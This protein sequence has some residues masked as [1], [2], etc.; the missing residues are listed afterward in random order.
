M[1]DLYGVVFPSYRRMAERPRFPKPFKP[2]RGL[3][4]LGG[5]F[6]DGITSVEGTP[7]QA[8]IRVL[9]RPEAGEPGDGVLVATTMSA[10]DGTWRIDGLNPD[11]KYD[12]VCRHRGYNDMILSNVSPVAAAGS[13]Q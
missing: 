10:P 2:K 11:L 6:P 3:G 7:G 9:Y 12:V 1:T 8:E 5:E 13:G 4:Y